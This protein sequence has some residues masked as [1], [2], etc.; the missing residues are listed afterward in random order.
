MEDSKIPSISQLERSFSSMFSSLAQLIAQLHPADD[1]R[2][3]LPDESLDPPLDSTMQVT[4][5]PKIGRID[6]FF[7][8]SYY[9]VCG[10]RLK[11]SF[12]KNQSFLEDEVH[13]RFSRI[14]HFSVFGQMSYF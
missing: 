11:T 4:P 14:S 7:R 6:F 1:E 13:F 2:D 3:V 8:H 9:S 10:L 12:F 5:F